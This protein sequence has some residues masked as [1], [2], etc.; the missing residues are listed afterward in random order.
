VKFTVLREFTHGKEQAQK[1]SVI[2]LEMTSRVQKMIEQRY[3]LI[4]ETDAPSKTT[5]AAKAAKGD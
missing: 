1:G 5:K 2:E 4:A 3:L